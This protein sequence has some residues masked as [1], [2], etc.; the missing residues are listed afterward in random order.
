MNRNQTKLKLF[1]ATSATTNRLPSPAKA[2][3]TSASRLRPTSKETPA[4]VRL[5]YAE[6]TLKSL[7]SAR[8]SAL[9]V[10][11]VSCTAA[12]STPRFLSSASKRVHLLESLSPLTF[13]LAR[14]KAINPT[15]PTQCRL[16]AGNSSGWGCWLL[17]AGNRYKVQVNSAAPG[18]SADIIRKPQL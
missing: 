14:F 4:L 10:K 1:T 9:Q 3:S 6:K 5:P 17:D 2:T 13:K 7:S 18:N 8:Q 15:Y 12:T 16:R 11:W